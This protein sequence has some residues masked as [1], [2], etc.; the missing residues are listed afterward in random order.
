MPLNVTLTLPS[1]VEIG[2]VSATASAEARL[3]PKMEI[4]PPGAIGD[5][6]LAAL[7]TP[8]AGAIGVC[9]CPV[10]APASNT[11][12]TCKTAF[13]VTDRTIVSYFILSEIAHQRLIPG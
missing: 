7:M 5:K 13:N 11:I 10:T 9:D 2:T 12:P 8:A 3:L 6:K 1:D 4:S